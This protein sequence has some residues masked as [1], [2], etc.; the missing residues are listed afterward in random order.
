MVNR[1]ALVSVM[2]VLVMMLIVL[3]MGVKAAPTERGKKLFKVLNGR[4]PPYTGP[5]V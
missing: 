1:A 3:G 4:F 5:M 2:K